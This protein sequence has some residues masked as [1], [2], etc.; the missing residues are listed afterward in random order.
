MPQLIHEFKPALLA[1]VAPHYLKWLWRYSVA[2]LIVYGLLWSLDALGVLRSYLPALIALIAVGLLLA[3]QGHA[4][5]FLIFWAAAVFTNS[6]TLRSLDVAL[7]FSVLSLSG[8]GLATANYWALT[9]S[10]MPG[11][12]IGPGT[13]AG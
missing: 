1:A 6:I 13:G 4:A 8:L 5:A 7:F 3:K 2:G 12:G 11:A 9:Q 10:L